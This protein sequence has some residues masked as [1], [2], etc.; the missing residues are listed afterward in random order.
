M[1]IIHLVPLLNSRAMRLRFIQWYA[2]IAAFAAPRVAA[3]LFDLANL[4]WRVKSQNGTINIPAS[5]PP[6]QVHLDLLKAGLI[7]EPLLETN[8]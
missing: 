1:N 7:T 6:S 5:A 8:G 3:D 2:A 4:Q